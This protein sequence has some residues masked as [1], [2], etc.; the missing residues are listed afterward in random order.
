MFNGL[1][2]RRERNTKAVESDYAEDVI[3]KVF[4]GGIEWMFVSDND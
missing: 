3:K 2:R 4:T 1:Q